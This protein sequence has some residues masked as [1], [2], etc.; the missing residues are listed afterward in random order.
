MSVPPLPA[1]QQP[2]E[3]RRL[4]NHSMLKRNFIT[5]MLVAVLPLVNYIS[6]VA[7]F[8]ML[9]KTGIISL[10]SKL[11]VSSSNIRTNELSL[12]FSVFSIFKTLSRPPSQQQ[13]FVVESWVRLVG[14]VNVITLFDD[15]A[16][17]S[18]LRSSYP[19]IRCVGVP[20]C[21]HSQFKRPIVRCVFEHGNRLAVTDHVVFVNGDILLLPSANGI[22]KFVSNITVP[23]L[24]TS[25]RIGVVTPSN[26]TSFDDALGQIQRAMAAEHAHKIYDGAYID[27]FVYSRGF[28]PGKLPECITGAFRWDN[29]LMS[30]AMTTAGAFVIDASSVM[31]I[32]HLEPAGYQTPNYYKDP[33]ANHNEKLCGTTWRLQVG[34]M[35]YAEYA[36]INVNDHSF[37][38]K[39]NWEKCSAPPL[40]KQAWAV[41]RNQS[42]EE[43]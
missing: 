32:V 12:E 6:E 31:K 38:L 2:I 40:V 7:R 22:F 1:S 35:Q 43:I 17:C 20:N 28:L 13:L 21:L 15:E 29:W 34:R 30:H 36:L 39:R 18:W 26:T 16:S 3:H 42:C 24:L 23:Y 37:R 11:R 33:A 19:Y 25:Q 10:D 4:C 5:V 8:A 9:S 27:M 14:Q 41:S